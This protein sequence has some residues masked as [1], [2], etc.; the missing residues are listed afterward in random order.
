MMTTLGAYLYRNTVRVVSVAAMAAVMAVGA[1]AAPAQYDGHGWDDH[2]RGGYGSRMSRSDIQR[3]AIVNGYADG[4]EHGLGDRRNR[5]SFNYQHA[6]EYR[7]ARSG[8]STDWRLERDYQNWYRQGYSRGY[9]DAYYGRSRNRD[10]DRGRVDR[11]PSANRYPAYGGGYGSGGYYDNREGDKDRDDV[12]RIAAQNGYNSGFQRGQY[13]AQQRN[14][15]NP[16]GHGAYQ[17]GY[18]G[19][20]R[21]WGSASTYQQYYRQYFV[22][23]YQDGYNRRSFNRSPYRR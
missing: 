14:R 16:Q 20:D 13:D 15:P 6:D 1:S 12:A 8:Y 9:S 3:L 17:F 10:Y 18:D 23:G 5:E 4:Y 7:N 2:G 21:S 19:F 22:Q 11:Y